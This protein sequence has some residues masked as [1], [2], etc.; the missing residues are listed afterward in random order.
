MPKGK[1]IC[2]DSVELAHLLSELETFS[3][4]LIG[5]GNHYKD[6]VKRLRKELVKGVAK[7]G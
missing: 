7:R 2:F 1:K 6:V 3:D 4:E 5:N